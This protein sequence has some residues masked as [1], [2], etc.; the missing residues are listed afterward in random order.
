MIRQAVDT[1]GGLD[2]LVLNAG[3]LRDKMIFNLDESD[4]DAVIKVHLKGHFAPA[5][6]ASAY[7]RERE[8]EP[9][10]RV[11]ASVITHQFARRACRATSARPTTPRPRPGSPCSR[12]RWLEMERYGVRA[13][14]VAPSGNTRL[15]GMTRVTAPTRPGAGPVRGV[16]RGTRATSPRS[17]CGWGRICPSTSTG[18]S[19]CCRAPRSTTTSPY[20]RRHR[21]RARRRA[22]VGAR[23]DQPGDE[24]GG[25][26]QPPRGVVQ[27]GRVRRVSA[28]G[29]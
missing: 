17:S 18:R 22:E 8:Q 1:F 2:I 21:Q 7:W 6:H 9:A 14:C 25:V 15:I 4:W 11:N 10:A 27:R 3:I 29:F 16:R 23:G 24:L 20:A 13:N 26:R 19:S 12:S 5:R 28:L